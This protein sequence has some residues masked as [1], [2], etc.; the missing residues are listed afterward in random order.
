MLTVKSA[1]KELADGLPEDATWSE[2]LYRI[3]VRQ[4]I[5]EGLDDIRAGRVVPHDEVFRELEEDDDE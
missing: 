5:E 3:V 4:K 1:V 2:V